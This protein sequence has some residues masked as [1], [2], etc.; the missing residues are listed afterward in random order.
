[1]AMAVPIII[2]SDVTVHLL[3]TP[4]KSIS[5]DL[6]LFSR[7][8]HLKGASHVIPTLSVSCCMQR[9]HFMIFLICQKFVASKGSFLG[10][11]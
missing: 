1:M 9:E 7:L 5:G 10:D 2:L 4:N 11:L 6:C 8:L 3:V